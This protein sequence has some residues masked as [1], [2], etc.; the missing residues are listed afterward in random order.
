MENDDTFY[1]IFTK[2]YNC[3]FTSATPKM[4]DSEDDNYIDNEDITG[5]VKY[6]YE[7]G[8]A[9]QERGQKPSYLPRR[10]QKF[11]LD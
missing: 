8:E 6:S 11:R 5:K 4:Y 9:I 7:F 1:K 10:A 2:G 3:L